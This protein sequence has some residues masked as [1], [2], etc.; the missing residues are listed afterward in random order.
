MASMSFAAPLRRTPIRNPVTRQAKEIHAGENAATG[1]AARQSF[2]N[3]E[4][5]C[6]HVPVLQWK[7]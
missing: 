3:A 2:T 4:S 6:V 1:I 7:E 5:R